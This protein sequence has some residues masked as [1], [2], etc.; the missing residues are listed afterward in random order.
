[1]AALR[2]RAEGLVL[3]GKVARGQDL[4]V[5]DGRVVGAVA[6]SVVT[7]G[8]APR[9]VPALLASAL[10]DIHTHGAFGVAF[11]QV[12][13]EH[14]PEALERL[15]SGLWQRGVGAFVASLP[16]LGPEHLTRQLDALAPFA[17]RLQAGRATLLGV[18]LEG[19][20]LSPKRRGAHAAENLRAPD[21][22]A[23]GRFMDRH[24]GLVR[25]VTLAP[26]AAG[27]D[28]LAAAV[29]ER[30]AVAAIGHSDA[31][32]EESERAFA[33]GMR[34][35]T[36]LWNAMPP[37]GH[38][39]PGVVGAV[40]ESPNVTAELVCDGHHLDRRVV[41]LTV[42]RLGPHRVCLVTD[43]MAAAGLGDGT[44][45]LGDLEATVVGGVARAPDGVLAGST[46][47]LDTAVQN[48][49]AWGVASVPWAHAMASSV[50]ARVIAA[51]GFGSLGEGSVATL[52]A[53][54]DD[55]ALAPLME[56]APA[57]G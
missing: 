45:R 35:A 23:L 30:G 16:S 6:T 10:V 19:P 9:E 48:I 56:D 49:V 26:E 17:G 54:G 27:G 13:P 4:L 41:A 2:Y 14:A 46:L 22:A 42:H 38:R 37:L 12:E 20:Y 34:H 28:A 51:E 50:P 1:M 52:V 57:P 33:A 25:M 3:G 43:A 5:R 29:L 32:A 39:A 40:L 47:M 36:H 15:R 11:D 18:H 8:Y 53:V 44:Y 55:G 31:T 21:G 7:P 24:P